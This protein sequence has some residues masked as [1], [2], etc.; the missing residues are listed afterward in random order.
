RREQAG[1]LNAECAGA[2]GHVA[3]IRVGQRSA[4]PQV[5][6]A[7]CRPARA[8][9]LGAVRMQVRTR[10][11][12]K[13]RIVIEWIGHCRQRG[14]IARRCVEYSYVIER[15][16]LICRAS[17]LRIGQ[18]AVELHRLQ[19]ERA[20]CCSRVTGETV[21]LARKNPGLALADGTSC[22]AA[23]ERGIALRGI[24]LVGIAAPAAVGMAHQQARL[25]Q[26]FTETK[27]LH[28]DRSDW[29]LPMTI[30]LDRDT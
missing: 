13:R 18:L 28:D 5:H 2:R 22:A 10:T 1:V 23:Y 29:Q 4:V 27:A 17:R 19:T 12:L 6:V 30:R 11:R 25:D 8:V 9:T 14:D 15:D 24:P 20:T 26:A 3:R 16:E 21:G 7:R